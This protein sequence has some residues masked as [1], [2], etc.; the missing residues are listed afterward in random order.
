LIKVEN[1]EVF[2]FE[3]SFR[4]LRNPLES[5]DKSDSH[6]GWNSSGKYFVIGEEDMKLALKLIKAGS[7]HSK[8]TRQIFVSMDIT[9][10]RSWWIEADTYKIGTTANST[11][12]MHNIH[13]KPFT[14]ED[15]SIDEI[16]K[17]Q[18]EYIPINNNNEIWKDIEGYE[19]SY[20]I[21]NTGRIKSCEREIE[22]SDGVIIKRKERYLHPVN[23]EGYMKISLSKN[24]IRKK[25]S[26]HRLLAIAFIENKNNY[27]IVNHKDGI[28]LNNNLDN[29]EWCTCSF[30]VQHAWNNELNNNSNY[31]RFKNGYSRR[32]FN[33]D[34]MELI[35]IEHSNGIA[36]KELAEKYNCGITTIHRIV[37]N[38]LYKNDFI[39]LNNNSLDGIKIVIDILNDLRELYIETNDKKYWRQII[40]L[41][42]QSY[43]QKRTWT[44]NY[45]GLRNMYFQR[46]NHKLQEWKDFC[47]VIKGLPYSEL[48]VVE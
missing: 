39:D 3:N 8:F 41:L 18:N 35:K 42:P 13:K 6:W 47:D 34:T 45:Q 2:N 24:G 9:A 30:N 32:K 25:Y 37:N 36:Y 4:G 1:I 48:I 26:L 15:F 28:K 5:W 29:L 7:E 40:E 11:S 21:S 12:T 43:N 38:I 14:L 22:K 33:E 10:P 17:Y 31:R 23:D 19:G 16:K 27:E 44:S 46:R 20:Q